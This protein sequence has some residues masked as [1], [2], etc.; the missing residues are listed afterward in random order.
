MVAA[1]PEAQNYIIKRPRLTNI[2]DESRARILLLCAPAGYG[3]TTLAREWIATRSEPVAWY[4]GGAEM[5]D[6]AA[7]ASG[8]AEALAPMTQGD[9]AERVAA[10]AA[11]NQSPAALG[12]AL[13]SAVT[14]ASKL[15]LVIDDYHL[16]TPSSDS[17]ALICALV[18]S[19]PLRVLLTSRIRPTW[20][21]HR[22]SVY[23]EALLVGQEELA[24]TDAEAAEV[25]TAHGGTG[26]SDILTN[27]RGWPAVIGLAAFS[28]DAGDDLASNTLPAE[29]YEY[30][31]EALFRDAKPELQ[32]TLFALALAGGHATVVSEVVGAHADALI[33]VAI[34]KGFATKTSDGAI[35]LHP[36]LRT[37]LLRKF[38]DS[39]PVREFGRIDRSSVGPWP[40]LG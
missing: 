16:A 12:R 10:L 21:T 22:M 23:G 24:F 14:D 18:T 35:G 25:L 30:F 20:V 17:E 40:S 34:A 11:R 4:R 29:L 15:T 32:N 38:R 31:A 2:L 7:V 36:L 8:L 27:A 26:H 1:R 13:A 3:K 19:S 28:N 33:S 6:V 39:V 37:F 5:L 9:L